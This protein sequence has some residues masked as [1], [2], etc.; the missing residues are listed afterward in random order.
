VIQNDTELRTTQER[1]EFFEK[2]IAQMRVTCSPTEF[3][4]M[5]G[6]WLA[7]V[8]KMHREVMEYLSRHASEIESVKVA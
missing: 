6:A 8:E 4:H 2:S 7:E 5:S 3:P 1:I